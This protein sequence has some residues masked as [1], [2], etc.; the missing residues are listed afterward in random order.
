MPFRVLCQGATARYAVMTTLR[1]TY[2]LPVQCRV[3]AVSRGGGYY[4]WCTR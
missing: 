3:L 4:A 1:L 2:P